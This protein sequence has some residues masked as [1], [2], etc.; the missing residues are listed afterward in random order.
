MLEL[1]ALDGI[2]LRS[3]DGRD[4]GAVLAQPKRL[5]LL[6]Y[7]ALA[8]PRGFQRRDTLVGLFWPERDQEHARGA[9]RKTVQ[10][11]RRALGEGFIV[12]RGED[13]LAVDRAALWCDVV[14]FE[15]AV[16]DGHNAEALELYRSDL[17]SGFF[18]SDAPG[19]EQWLE[20]KRAR[21][22]EVASRAARSLAA[23]YE[24]ER[25][26]TAAVDSA[27]TRSAATLL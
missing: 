25:N 10:L 12:A 24:A 6:A 23:Q 4:V 18:L 17:L 21:L 9:L 15:G 22:R 3:D 26:V 16:K 11:L 7:L 27:R 2:D 20:G 13:E 8:V 19:F 14:A 1:R 5:A